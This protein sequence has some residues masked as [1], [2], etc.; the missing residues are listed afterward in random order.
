[1]PIYADLTLIYARFSRFTPI[2]RFNRRKTGSGA[3]GKPQ[4]TH[5]TPVSGPKGPKRA[6][7]TLFKKYRAKSHGFE[8]ILFL[9]CGKG[10]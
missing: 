4:N 10:R 9:E 6:H 7:L 1:M 5:V 8:S 3:K 2:Y